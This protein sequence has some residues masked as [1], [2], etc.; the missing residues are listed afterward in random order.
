MTSILDMLRE[1]NSALLPAPVLPSP[2][3]AQP[4]AGQPPQAAEPLAALTAAPASPNHPQASLPPPRPCQCGFR[5]FWLDPYG[6]LRCQACTPPKFAFQV[7]STHSV[8]GETP[9]NYYWQQFSE[10][11]EKIISELVELQT[12]C[13]R[14]VIARAGWDDLRSENFN[15]RLC[16]AV[17]FGLAEADRIL[18]QNS[19]YLSGVLRDT[20]TIDTLPGPWPKTRENYS[21]QA[22][23]NANL[24]KRKT[25]GRRK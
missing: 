24:P 1:S 15:Q 16:L 11:Q 22:D 12:A 2:A 9:E 17:E 5:T 23:E 10:S 19:R 7:K 13:G 20:G 3:A 8:E 25:R 18:D 4:P 21:L 6:T 14:N